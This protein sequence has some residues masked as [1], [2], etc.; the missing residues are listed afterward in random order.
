MKMISLLLYISCHMMMIPIVLLTF[1]IQ[2]TLATTTRNIM[3]RNSAHHRH[4][5]E[6][7]P[8]DTY[9]IIAN[10]DKDDIFDDMSIQTWIMFTGIVFVAILICICGCYCMIRCRI[11]RRRLNQARRSKV[12]ENNN[13]QIDNVTVSTITNTKGGVATSATTAGS[14]QNENK[15][16]VVGA[17]DDKTSS[18][19]L[20]QFSKHG[21]FVDESDENN[22]VDIELD[23]DDDYNTKNTNVKRNKG[24]FTWR[25][26]NPFNNGKKM[27]L[28]F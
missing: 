10:I 22:M 27:S 13:K 18:W 1:M 9:N 26:S 16:E 23:D 14:T 4:I 28:A 6:I 20:F 21:A 11:R 24:W 3:W 19:W 12:F 8:V 17:A 2:R 15:Y 25:S 7:D 5:Q